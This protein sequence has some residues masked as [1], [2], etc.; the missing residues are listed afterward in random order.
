MKL[1]QHYVRL[2]T[3]VEAC[4]L[5]DFVLDKGTD[6]YACITPG[7]V[8]L[9]LSD[10]CLEEVKAFCSSSFPRFELSQ[11][12]PHETEKAIIQNLKQSG[13]I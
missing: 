12:H 2:L 6:D 13:I 3:Y 1:K 9:S 10:E 7:G 11:T 4:K 8:S 5:I